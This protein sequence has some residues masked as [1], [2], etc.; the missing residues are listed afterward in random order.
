[1]HNSMSSYEFLMQEKQTNNITLIKEVANPK[2]KIRVTIG[3]SHGIFTDTPGTLFEK[4]IMVIPRSG[5]FESNS[6]CPN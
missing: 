4:L 5:N 1:M 2:Q 6:L 3:L